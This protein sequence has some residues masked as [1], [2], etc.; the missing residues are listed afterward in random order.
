MKSSETVWN[1]REF[2]FGVLGDR[3][4]L[5]GLRIKL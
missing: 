2:E 3:A 4:G 5:G 1:G